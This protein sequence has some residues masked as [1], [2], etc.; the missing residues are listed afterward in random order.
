[1]HLTLTGTVIRKFRAND[2]RVVW[3]FTKER[4]LITAFANSALNVKKGLAAGT[5]LFAYGNFDI[6]YYKD[7]Y[8]INAMENLR[9]FNG[10]T[11]DVSVL[12]LASYIAELSSVIA[13]KEMPDEEMFRLYLNVMHFLDKGGKDLFLLKAIFELRAISLAGFMPDLVCCSACGDIELE[14]GVWFSISEGTFVCLSCY[15]D[16]I[17]GEEVF[18]PISVLAAMRHIVYSELEELFSFKLSEEMMKILCEVSQKYILY[19]TNKKYNTLDFMK[20]I[21]M[22]V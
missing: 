13:P 12:A 11:K 14:G 7:R 20:S 10:L 22:D 3:L 15:K 2:G 4:G 21:G 1:M 19:H 6:F 17:R 16:K 18:L 5:D 9:R 8:T